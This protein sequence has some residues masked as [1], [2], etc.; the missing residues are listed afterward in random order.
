MTTAAR[1]HT[2]LHA[3]TM[4][5]VQEGHERVRQKAESSRIIEQT[6][7]IIEELQRARDSIAAD[8]NSTPITLAKLHNPIKSSF[9]A[10]NSDLKEIYTSHNKYTRLLDKLF[11]NKPLP[12]SDIDV[13]SPHPAYVNRAIY[14]H[15]LREGLFDVA[16]TLGS[17]SL[18]ATNLAEVGWESDEDGSSAPLGMN[19]SESSEMQ[20]QFTTMYHILRQLRENHNLQPAILWAREHAEALE[21]RGSNLEFELCRLQFVMVFLGEDGMR[22]SEP[23][24]NQSRALLFAWQELQSFSTR[25]LPELRQLAAAL[26]YSP[27]LEE[28]P[29]RHIFDHQTAWDHV[30]AS[31]TREFCG[32]M[33]LSA[34]SPLYIAATAGAIALPTL[35]KLQTIM[36]QKRT[37]WTTENELPVE[38]P[39]PPAY[40][41]HAIFVCPV[42]KEQTTDSNPPMMM[43]CGHVVAQESLQRL[44]KGGKFKCPYCPGESHPRE[45]IKIFL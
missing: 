44:S 35:L 39:L 29:Y 2:S 24:A 34:E 28:S 45:A 43:P 26:A 20:A 12:S 25:Y 18:T 13:L 1:H 3:Y 4:D 8:P 11:K 33:K 40:Q 7:S 17:E 5:A 15:L 36:Q 9:E 42:S 10:I 27:N 37:E 22:E 14:L 6:Q 19:E 23:G 38:T 30:S 16:T 41:F 21:K 31:F 32:L